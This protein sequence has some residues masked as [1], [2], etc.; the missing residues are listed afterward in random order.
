M[1]EGT[2]VDN[3]EEQAVAPITAAQAALI[4]EHLPLVRQVVFQIAVRFPRHV[5]REDLVR[6][7][8]IGLVE[9]ARRY[10]EDRGVPFPRFAAQRIRGAVL[11]G[12]RAADW[13]PRSVR[14]MAK[15]VED[16]EQKLRTELGRTATAAEVA[17]VLGTTTAAVISAKQRARTS[18]VLTL[19]HGVTAG[20][21]DVA[22][23]DVV[24]DRTSPEPEEVL[25]GVELRSYLHD[26]VDLLPD[27]HREVIA[28]YFLNGKTSEELA[29]ELGVTTSRVSQLRTE[30][31]EM[32]KEGI[33]AQYQPVAEGPPRGRVARRK[34]CYAAAIAGRSPWRSRLNEAA[35]PLARIA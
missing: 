14:T 17:A 31:L 15:A 5:D 6:V 16:A 26:A 11:D 13:A 21:D 2:K 22:L 33:E 23:V 20:D 32:L 18:I 4:E 7:G 9:A 24:I 28:G 1:F 12:L 35:A 29:A 19:D 3:R 34:A 25:E 30:A 8:N 10:S 27:R